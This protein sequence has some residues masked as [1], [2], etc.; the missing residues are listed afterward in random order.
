MQNNILSFNIKE[1]YRLLVDRM[2][3][4]I[5]SSVHPSLVQYIKLEPQD[6]NGKDRNEWSYNLSDNTIR[7]PIYGKG[8]ILE[9][10]DYQVIAYLLHE[11]GH[12]RFTEK[13]EL[14]E[15]PDPIYVFSQ[16][17]NA[18]ED[19][20]IEHKMT[21]IYP[22]TYDSF[23]RVNKYLLEGIEKEKMETIP[24]YLNYIL[25][26]RRIYMGLQPHFTDKT[27]EVYTKTKSH[28]DEVLQSPTTGYLAN[29]L[30]LE[31]IWPIFQELLDPE[32]QQ[33]QDSSSQPEPNF[34]FD[35]SSNTD[36]SSNNTEEE[37]Q[38]EQN[39]QQNTPTPQGGGINYKKEANIDKI[40]EDLSDN[41]ADAIPGS[42][43]LV[44]L[45][46]PEQQDET[47]IDSKE[48]HNYDRYNNFKSY[49]EL[50]LTV[51]PYINTFA[52]KLQS[53]LKDNNY[54]RYGGNFYNGKLDTKKLY[55]WKCNNTRIFNKKIIRSNKAYAVTLLIDNSGSMNGYQVYNA[56]LSAVLTAEV[57]FRANIPFEITYFNSEEKILKS[58]DEP[59]TWKVKRKMETIIPECG[60]TTSDA[61]M[62]NRAVY[63]LSKRQEE[64]ILLVMSDGEPAPTS[65]AIFP[66]DQRRLKG[67]TSH[68][69][70]DLAVEVGKGKQFAN[71]IGI[72]ILTDYV[73]QYYPKHI[74]VRK[75]EQL[76][77]LLLN[78]IKKNI[79]RG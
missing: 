54:T 37:N 43:K 59:F 78:T 32:N 11:I 47:K 41:K 53:I 49:E 9:I 10:T 20:R 65:D 72:G 24:L 46:K 62:I 19:V 23:T 40:I 73:N 50:Y 39:D 21:E 30:I 14:Q 5:T 76:P 77:K 27:E 8:G 36:T 61:Y 63:R 60:G 45:D 29:V 55:R 6:Q 4:I 28:I 26:V 34:D 12:S 67:K 22:G 69:E 75:I 42:E 64:R 2:E 25:N 17:L 58:F 16:L 1:K 48:V 7:Y 70:F 35:S 66:E 33:E 38:S 18:L 51:R 56:T 31:K 15:I 44:D 13:P 52:K 74:V 57:L 71:I 68:N 79:T 3:S